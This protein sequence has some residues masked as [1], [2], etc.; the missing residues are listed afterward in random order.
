MNNFKLIES[1]IAESIHVKKILLKDISILEAVFKLSEDC[2]NA[3]NIGGKII[4]CG[5]GG[6]FADAQHLSAELV[7]RLNFDRKPLASLVLGANAS[8]ISAIGNDYGYDSVFSR[9]LEC[10]GQVGDIFIPITTSGESKN[11][12]QAIGTAKSLGIK[13]VCFTGNRVSTVLSVCSCIAVPSINTTRIQE[14]HILLGHIL[15]GLIE[16]RIFRSAND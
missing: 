2:V 5:N 9:E 11:I 8:S 14:C 4:F 6:S 7:G 10:I 16:E 12:V 15:C 13:T 3:L 1:E